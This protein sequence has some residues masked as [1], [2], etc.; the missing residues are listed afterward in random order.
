MAE[1]TETTE[2]AE[3]IELTPEQAKITDISLD[4][5]LEKLSEKV[6]GYNAKL[7]LNHAM[8]GSGVFGDSQDFL[9]AKSAE[10][11]CLELIKKGGPSFQVGRD[12][13]SRT[14]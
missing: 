8:V 3:T 9:N 12:L 6:S 5:V 2:A 14:Q 7:L 1:K 10:S 11:I 13:Y 4:V